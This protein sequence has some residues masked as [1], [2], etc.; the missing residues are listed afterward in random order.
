[1]GYGKGRVWEF[2]KRKTVYQMRGFPQL[3]HA[4]SDGSPVLIEDSS[5]RTV[6]GVLWN[7]PA[8]YCWIK[9]RGFD[10]K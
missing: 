5:W 6:C 2:Q 3:M 8:F 7:G 9:F 4:H 10:P 1:M